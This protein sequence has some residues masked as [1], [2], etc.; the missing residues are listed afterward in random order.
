MN[1][2]CS[3]CNSSTVVLLEVIKTADLI[4]MYSKLLS[5]DVASEFEQLTEIRLY[6]CPT[7]D[8]RFFFPGAAGSEQFYKMMQKFDW[9]YMDDKNEYE[10]VKKFVRETDKVLEV[11]CGKGAFALKIPTKAY[12]GLELS[13]DAIARASGNGVMVLDESVEQH[14]MSNS[15]KYD[16]VCAFQVLEH[17]AEPRSFI[18]ACVSCLRPGG[19]LIYSLPSQDSFARYVPNFVLDLPPHHM[20]RWSD[21][22]LKSIAKIFSLEVVEIWH[23]PLQFV[24]RQFYAETIF[25]YAFLN[26]LKKKVKTVDLSL[27]L[28]IITS[29]SYYLAKIFVKGLTTVE[30]FPRGIS[31]TTIYRKPSMP[32]FAHNL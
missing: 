31:V 9:Y 10:Y 27:T 13:P 11:G 26:V 23:E 30:L 20:A 7:C 24:H 29:L 4:R 14:A 32:T 17:I 12:V 16:I 18:G 21:E 19:L 22:V 8:L 6:H 1:I 5:I 2:Q 28:R 3:L 15:E 25:N